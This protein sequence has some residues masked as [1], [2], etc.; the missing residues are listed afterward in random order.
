ETW[1]RVG[2]F[3]VSR[4]DGLALG[5]HQEGQVNGMA[6]EVSNASG[7]DDRGEVSIIAG[8]LTTP[9]Q[10]RVVV[11]VVGQQPDGLAYQ[12]EM[13]AAIDSLAVETAAGPFDAM[14]AEA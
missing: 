6:L 11:I 7:R 8:M 5:A 1:D 9:A 12:A 3:L 4:F 13:Q 14:L 10:Q 2:N